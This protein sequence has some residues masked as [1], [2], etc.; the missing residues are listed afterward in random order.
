MKAAIKKVGKNYEIQRYKGLGE[1]DAEQLWETTMNPKT[2][3]LMKVTLDNLVAIEKNITVFM[4]NNTD[5]RKEY[6]LENM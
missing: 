6:L 5:S 4:G 2:R 3:T 1:M